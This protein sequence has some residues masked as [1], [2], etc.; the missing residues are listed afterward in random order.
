MKNKEESERLELELLPRALQ[1]LG[2][3]PRRMAL[4]G[5][6]NVGLWALELAQTFDGVLAFEPVEQTYRSLCER[7]YFLHNVYPQRLA[8]LD[9]RAPIAM[10]NPPKR[11]VSTAS[12][13]QRCEPDDA[14]CYAVA[15]DE[16]CLEDLDFLKLD[17]EGAELRALEGARHTLERLQPL[18]LVEVI[19][20]QLRRFGDSVT[21]LEQFLEAAGYE[22]RITQKPNRVY[23]KRPR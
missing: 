18:I 3:R 12:Y 17:L 19:E 20:K 10:T 16:L 2:D 9:A 1:L 7:C 4:D 21:A 11:T 15:I 13:A 22:I 8:L 23:T 6:A 5:G 14:S